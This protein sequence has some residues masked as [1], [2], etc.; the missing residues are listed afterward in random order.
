MAFHL[1]WQPPPRLDSMPKPTVPSSSSAVF[2]T[3]SVQ[4]N[5]YSFVFGSHKYGANVSS[6]A[7]FIESIGHLTC[8]SDERTRWPRR[9]IN[10][11]R[12]Y[13]YRDFFFVE[14]NDTERT[15]I[16]L[17]NFFQMCFSYC[18]R[19]ASSYFPISEHIFHCTPC[20]RGVRTV[21]L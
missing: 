14:A 9:T 1:Q 21:L 3:H 11:N 2:R 5:C 19:P 15:Q 13:I 10:G 20:V 17:N 18:C 7:P 6:V 8:R 12:L 16:P 4:Q